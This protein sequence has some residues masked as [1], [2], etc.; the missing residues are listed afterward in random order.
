MKI[1]IP[2]EYLDGIAIAVL[3]DQLDSL[4]VDYRSRKDGGIPAGIYS[5]DLEEDLRKINKTIRAFKRVLKYN[6][7]DCE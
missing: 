2:S 6:G 3:R 5:G 7:I 4:Q 1:D